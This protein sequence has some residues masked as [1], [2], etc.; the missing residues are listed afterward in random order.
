MA[1]EP[2]LRAPIEGWF[3]EAGKQAENPRSVDH[4]GQASMNVHKNRDI[5]CRIVGGVLSEISLYRKLDEKIEIGSLC[6]LVLAEPFYFLTSTHVLSSRCIFSPSIFEQKW[7]GV[8][9][10]CFGQFCTDR[11]VGVRVGLQNTAAS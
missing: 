5:L 7:I 3:Q 2:R 11:F 10:D 8:C 1:N 6:Q 9:C 4:I